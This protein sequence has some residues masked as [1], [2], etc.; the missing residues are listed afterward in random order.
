M[1]DTDQS[2]A[3]SD[4]STPNRRQRRGCRR[5]LFLGCG[6]V[7]VLPVVIFLALF[8]FLRT[9]VPRSYTPVAQPLPPPSLAD[10]TRLGLDGA[11]SPYLGHTGAWDGKGGGLFGKSKIPDL[12]K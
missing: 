4:E 11:E 6:F 2:P 1:T 5:R 3:H 10:Y 9:S 7:L 8:L 12:E